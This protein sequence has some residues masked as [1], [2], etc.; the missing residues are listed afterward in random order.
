MEQTL[1]FFRNNEIFIY[2]GLGVLILWQ[3]R[4]F[5]LAWSRLRSAAFGL[6]RE[7]AQSRLNRSAGM[8]VFYLILGVGEFALVSF[9]APSI[10]GVIPIWTPTVDLFATPEVTLQNQAIEEILDENTTPSPT[11]LVETGGCVSGSVEIISPEDGETVSGVV[12]ILGTANIPNFGFYKF[13][14]AALG[15]TSWLTVQAGETITTNGKLGFWDTTR[16]NQGDYLLR[17]VVS[18][19]KGLSYPP[20]S[21]KVRVASST[22][23]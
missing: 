14:M 9:I 23:P 1:R 5:S 21:V 19:N 6:E 11:L 20:C 4:K 3:I 17:L 10:P 18:D 12:E 22:E 8:L 16:L 2:I 15:D 7:N 13:E